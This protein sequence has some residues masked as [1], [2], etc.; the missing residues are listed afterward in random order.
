MRC[1]VA[2][3][4][5]ALASK[6]LGPQDSSL[7][8]TGCVAMDTLLLL[9]CICFLIYSFERTAYPFT[10][11]D[12]SCLAHHEPSINVS[13]LLPLTLPHPFGILYCFNLPEV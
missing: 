8:L 1:A 2:E 3:R 10:L 12:A 11:W 6:N 13:F 9:L 4:T 7:P 5:W